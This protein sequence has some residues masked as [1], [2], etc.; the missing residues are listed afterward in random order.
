MKR[1]FPG[2]FRPDD[3]EINS[4]WESGLF[5]P[6]ANVVL[7]LYQYS[8]KSRAEFIEILRAMRE[9]LWMPYQVG[10]EV[11]LN[12]LEKIG[13]QI[14]K[15]EET[16][17]NIEKIEADFKNNRS[18]PFLDHGAQ[19]SLTR[20]LSRVKRE[21]KEGKDFYEQR[22]TDDDILN[23]ISELFS[24]KTGEVLR[25]DQINAIVSAG[26]ERYSKKI[27]PGYMDAKKSSGDED[28]RPYGDL[29]IWEEMIEYCKEND[30]DAIFVTD[31]FKEDWWL[32]FNGKT[33]GPRPELIEEFR[34]RSGKRV[35]FYGSSRFFE[36]A[37]QRIDKPLSEDAQIEMK[38][39]RADRISRSR[40]LR[41]RDLFRSER[42]NKSWGILASGLM[43]QDP[44]LASIQDLMRSLSHEQD[45]IQSRLNELI[46]GSENGSLTDDEKLLADELLS[47]SRGLLLEIERLSVER[48]RLM[49]ESRKSYSFPE[50][51]DED[52]G[53]SD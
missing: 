53:G 47:K 39:I 32:E 28:V 35:L 31:D 29:I 2:H 9:R 40:A 25:E 16:L 48:E 52:R 6:D 37:S 13:A 5:V 7:G 14:K 11:L 24:G 41:E 20:V 4:I 19:N 3:I 34:G 45:L 44:R 12:R 38:N 18:Q 10:K 23:V 49:R 26:K 27:P 46:R 1:K 43:D 33:I 51:F 50:Y 21:L 15:Y 22:I 30:S 42:R 36:F 8:A 17:T